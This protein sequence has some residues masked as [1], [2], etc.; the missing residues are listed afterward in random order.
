MVGSGI[1]AKP[2]VNLHEQELDLRILLELHRRVPDK[3]VIDVGAK[4]GALVEAFLQAGCQ[5]LHALQPFSPGLP[6]LLAWTSSV[7]GVIEGRL[8]LP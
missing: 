8:Y 3:R 5:E 6:P 4:N 7:E 1:L 2:A